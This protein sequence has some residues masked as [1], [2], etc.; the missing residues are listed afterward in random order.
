MLKLLNKLF[1]VLLFS[2]FLFGVEDFERICEEEVLKE[3]FN[4]SVIQDA[5]FKT[6]KAYEKT[7]SLAEASGYF[8]L[9]DKAK[10]NIK[11]IDKLPKDA[12]AIYSN[13]GHSYML[14]NNF[15]EGEKYYKKFI[16][17]YHN[18]NFAMQTDFKE[19]S[20]LY[21]KY[22][23]QMIK[24]KKIWDKFYRPLTKLDKLYDELEYS[25]QSERSIALLKQIITIKEKH[26][27]NSLSLSSDYLSLAIIYEDR[28]S[29]YGKALILYK[30]MLTIFHN[31]LGENYFDTATAY[32]NIANIY[33]TQGKYTLAIATYKKAL[34]IDLKIFGEVHSE[35]AAIYHNMANVLVNIGDL[36][37][38]LKL[39]EKS[40]KID[41]QVLKDKEDEHIMATYHEMANLLSLQGNYDAALKLYFKILDIDLKHKSSKRIE[42]ATL[43]HNI[44]NA[45]KDKGQYHKSLNYYNKSLNITRELFG[46]KHASTITTLHNIAF[47]HHYLGNYE[48]ALS[49]Y[50]K[51][52]EIDFE[53]FGFNHPH[54]ATTYHHIAYI[55]QDK[56][57]YSEA[58]EIYNMALDIRERVLGTEH[59]GTASTYHN[60]GNILEDLQAYDLA[61]DEYHKALKIEI[62]VLGEKHPTTVNTY[63]NIANVLQSKKL[64]DESLKYYKKAL[65]ANL[66]NLRRNH[67]TISTNYHNI[68][69]SYFYKRDYK[70]AYLNTKKSFN[71]FLENRKN[72]I[73]SL[74]NFEKKKFLNHNQDIMRIS[75]LFRTAYFY[76]NKSVHDNS[77]QTWLNY[78]GTLFEYQNILN[79]LKHNPKTSKE[80]IET[81][82]NLNL[83]NIALSNA[84][85]E[86]KE[87]IQNQIHN[88]EV[89]LSKNNTKFQE[90]LDLKEVNT[91]QIANSL[92]PH[93]LYIDF[94]RANDN[95]YIFTL[96]HNDSISFQQI[97]ENESKI[98]DKNIAFYRENMKHMAKKVEKSK[99]VY[100]SQ[101][102]KN[103]SKTKAQF[104][105]SKLY[106]ILIQKYLKELI[107]NK[108]HL[109]IS[110]DGALNHLPF[111]AL[112]DKQ[113]YLV[114]NYQINYISSGKE[115]VRQTK[116][117]NKKPKREMILFANADF[118]A[119]V[120]AYKS[121]DKLKKMFGDPN[122]I[123]IETSFSNLGR[124]EIES[125]KK[126]Y[127][128]ALVFEDTNAS[129]TNLMSVQSSKILHLST[130]GIYLDDTNIQNPMR[131]SFLVF[132]GG[133]K[134]Q[135][136]SHI[137]AL[138]LSTLDLKDTE[139][140]V[141]SACQSGLGDIH[142]AEGV[143]GLPK[144]LLQAGAKNVL[145]SL[146]TVSNVKTALLMDYFYANI[147][148]KQSYSQA[149]QNAKIKMIKMHPYYWSAFILSGL[150]KQ[151]RKP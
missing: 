132:A 23:S 96:D 144:A 138:K 2:S 10:E 114:E 64:Y 56:K 150:N 41:F 53:I 51:V 86:N 72:N 136:A 119:K 36:K 99:D 107:K 25:E 78:K 7:N 14:V 95:Y 127:P 42:I 32:C 75:H 30:K 54:T 26:L 84:K 70:K 20:R 122:K 149:L 103:L 21:P 91:A 142:K 9:A 5:C 133:N 19:F 111:E 50:M 108:K 97:D 81:I 67:P 66:I 17:A 118:D 92:T 43:Y 11:N 104:Y 58:L 46:E 93:Q 112:Y 147:S 82:D 45:Y 61:L 89:N 151:K 125:I 24:A 48:K 15:I 148:K 80:T 55:Y 98:I 16:L 117:R 101:K 102:D 76:K 49:I 129:I 116:I 69:I 126:Y 128:D 40:L 60:I 113:Q 137:S 18:P 131:K 37:E 6:A 88:L 143:V 120:K 57:M 13:I 52:L 110:P 140:V 73:Q 33:N 87:E 8:F 124:K 1:L 28:F 3:D 62:N 29:R 38:A 34:S 145:M 109:I 135:K 68:G 130:H 71:I 44:A 85:E 63:H 39:Y 35:T 77:F 146:W 94:A 90:L 123:K 100:F 134:N 22:K 79:M 121:R 12:S 141:L 74:D 106:D 31:K 47:V 139:L 83:A 105:L 59:I 65:N 115:F 4:V 27:K